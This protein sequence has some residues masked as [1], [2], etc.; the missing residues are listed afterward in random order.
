M[1]CKMLLT[2]QKNNKLKK[3]G[4]DKLKKYNN[5]K[6]AIEE[7]DKLIKDKKMK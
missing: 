4:L 5:L 1:I 2:N 7:L 3:D 6:K